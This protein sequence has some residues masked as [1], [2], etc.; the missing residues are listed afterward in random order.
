MTMQAETLVPDWTAPDAYKTPMEIC[1]QFAYEISDEK[2]ANLYS[3]A[4]QNQWDAE[5]ALDWSVEIDPSKPII[6][7]NAHMFLRLPFFQKLSKTQREKFSAH[8]TAQLLSQFLHGEQGALMTASALTHAVPDYDA[9]LYCAT[10]TMDEARH[11]EVYDRYIKKLA[12]AYPISPWLKELIDATLSA[13]HYAKIMVGMNMVIEGL[14][15]AA[16]HNM[17]RQ[18]TCPLLRSIT[19][20][21]LRDESRHVAFGNVYLKETLAQMH[22]DER[23][24]VAE[25]AFKAVKSMADAQGGAD[26]KG[27]RKADPGFLKVLEHCDIDLQDFIAALTDAGLV[28]INIKL[29]PGHVH[30][31]RDLMMP[32]L[33]RVGAVTERSRAL[34][35]EAGLPV[36][37]DTTLLESMEESA[38]GD[39]V[40][41]DY[42]LSA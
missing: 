22:P 41:P 19:E 18:T 24:D 33:V 35:K 5:R 14:A 28:G 10:Q 9:K 16:F 25:F 15:L 3:K 38:T 36:W 4:K 27:H 32:A 17:R 37:D 2:L 31:F 29:P 30:S 20:Y 21:V 12:L 23:E 7:E 34:Y 6:D 42:T 13:D 39:I 8:A 40:F 26:G 11:V 1:W